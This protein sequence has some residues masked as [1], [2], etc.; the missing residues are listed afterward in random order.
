MSKQPIRHFLVVYDIARRQTDVRH[1]GTDYDA[2]QRAYADL[3]WET[4]TN[5]NVDAVLLSADSLETV[6]RTH[7]SYFGSRQRF[8]RLLPP[9]LLPTR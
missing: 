4:R 9:G 2:A 7:S 3:E 5:A 1:F 6:K 8:E